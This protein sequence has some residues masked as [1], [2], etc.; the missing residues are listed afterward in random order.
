MPE[1]QAPQSLDGLPGNSVAAGSAR[2]A[3]TRPG[4]ALPPAPQAGAGRRA[5]AHA[6]PEVREPRDGAGRA[7]RAGDPGPAARVPGT[8]AVRLG[9]RAALADGDCGRPCPAPLAGALQV[10]GRRAEPCGPGGGEGD[11]RGRPPPPG[12]GRKAEERRGPAGARPLGRE[13]R[14]KS[15]GDRLPGGLGRR[16]RQG[17]V[18]DFAPGPVVRSRGA[19]L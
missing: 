17:R 12:E 5:A 4:A 3:V 7:R 11:P 16:W 14:L 15:S 18:Q 8:P 9:P 19:G 2:R 1:K 10:S 13:R 6:R